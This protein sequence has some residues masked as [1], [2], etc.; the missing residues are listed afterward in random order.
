M[1]T[2]PEKPY[3]FHLRRE[4]ERKKMTQTELAAAVGV[5]Q[6]NISRIEAGTTYPPW[7]LACRIAAVLKTPLDRF[8]R[9]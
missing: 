5:T 6:A 4:R 1:T 7:Q 8:L 3:P 2:E 9:D